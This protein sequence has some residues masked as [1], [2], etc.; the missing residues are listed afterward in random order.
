MPPFIPQGNNQEVDPSKDKTL[1]SGYGQVKSQV[2]TLAKKLRII[3][4]SNARGS[5]DL[6]SLTD[7]P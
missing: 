6:D 2:E 3:E 4:G 7:S 1:K 5:V